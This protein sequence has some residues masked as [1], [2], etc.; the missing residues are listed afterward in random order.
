MDL[1]LLGLVLNVR[2]FRVQGI[3]L[4]HYQTK[5][6]AAISL[7]AIFHFQEAEACVSDGRPF[8]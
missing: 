5:P 8:E 7:K 2:L 6:N 1:W 4:P 3:L